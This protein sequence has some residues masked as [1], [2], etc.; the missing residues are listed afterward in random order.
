MLQSLPP[1]PPA[2]QAT[3]LGYRGFVVRQTDDTGAVTTIRVYK[4]AVQEGTPAGYHGD[5]GGKIET[6]LLNTGKSTLT[7]ETFD[8]VQKEVASH[9][10]H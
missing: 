8:Y 4:G 2:D 9:G 3:T 1:I 6:W 7:S 10:R 5:P